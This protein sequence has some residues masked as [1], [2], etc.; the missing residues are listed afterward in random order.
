MGDQRFDELAKEIATAS[1]RR[2]FVR[3]TIGMGLG[4]ATAAMVARDGEAARRGF[5]GPKVPVAT[6][7]P[8]P[9]LCAGVNCDPPGPCYLNG[10]CSAISGTCV[11]TMKECGECMVC[12]DAGVCEPIVCSTPPDPRCY[13]TPGFCDGGT[14][15]YTRI[16]C[17]AIP[18]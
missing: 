2:R 13:L 16:D 6:S 14:C 15:R 1:S 18:L 8:P 12:G 4:A 11:Y 7:T 3:R 5:S 9:D 10:R 17:E